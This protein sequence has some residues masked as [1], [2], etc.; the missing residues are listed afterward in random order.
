[1]T[2]MKITKIFVII[3]IVFGMSL[4]PLSS[5]RDIKAMEVNNF[6]EHEDLTDRQKEIIFEANKL[7]EINPYSKEQLVLELILKNYSRPEIH[8]I[9]E[10][11]NINWKNNAKLA[12]ERFVPTYFTRRSLEDRLKQ[13]KFTKEEIEFA[14]LNFEVN[15]S[16]VDW[17]EQAKIIAI[18]KIT[19]LYWSNGFSKKDLVKELEWE[20]FTAE[21]SLNA[22]N[23]F[24]IDWN[25]EAV[26]AAE[27]Y[28]K[29]VIY[30]GVSRSSLENELFRRNF[31]KVEVDF[32]L[33]NAT[34]NGD[35]INWGNQ[36]VIRANTYL[37][38]NVQFTKDQLI[39]F[40]INEKFTE[41]EAVYGAGIALEQ[42]EQ[43]EP[44][45]SAIKALEYANTL[46]ESNEGFSAYGLDM[47]LSKKGFNR[48]DIL[49]ALSKIE[50]D[51]DEQALKSAKYFLNS[52][53]S[54]R[55]ELESMLIRK[56]YFWE[57]VDYVM[58]SDKIDWFDQAKLFLTKYIEKEVDGYTKEDLINVLN[59]NGFEYEEVTHAI[60][61]NNIDWQKQARLLARKY[62]YTEIYGYSKTGLVKKLQQDGFIYIEAFEAV[63]DLN[64]SKK[65][66]N[67]WEEQ[68]LI[69][70]NKLIESAA[71][72]KVSLAKSL[73]WVGFYPKEIDYA[74]EKVIFEEIPVNWEEQA[75]R[76]LE[77]RINDAYGH[78]ESYTKKDWFEYL[79]R[80]KFTSNQSQSAIDSIDI[81]WKNY[82]AQLASIYLNNYLYSQFHL[83][84]NMKCGDFTDDEID[85]ALNNIFINWNYQ[86]VRKARDLVENDYIS[87]TSSLIN[88]LTNTY[89]FTNEQA[90]YAATNSDLDFLAIAIEAAE[91]FI[92]YDII[93]SKEAII[94][95]LI[96]QGFTKEDA[97]AALDFLKYNTEATEFPINSDF[98]D[99]II[100]VGDE[101]N[102]EFKSNEF[103]YN[104]D[105]KWH[106]STINTVRILGCGA[107][108][109]DGVQ[110]V[111]IGI[112]A[113]NPGIVTISLVDNNNEVISQKNLKV[114]K[115]DKPVGPSPDITP[116]PT[117]PTPPV[118][119]A[120]T[121]P[122]EPSVNP[123]D[124]KLFSD[125][126]KD[127][128]FYKYVTY[129]AEK[130]ISTGFTEGDKAGTFG[131]NDQLTRRHAAMLLI[132]ALG[133]DLP[134]YNNTFTDVK[135]GSSGAQHIQAAYDLGLISGYSN[136]D[137][138][139]AYK[140]EETLKRSQFAKMVAIAYNLE[141]DDSKTL[142]LTDLENNTEYNYIKAVLDNKIV[143]GY[144]DNTYG[145]HKAVTRGNV[146]KFIYNAEH[147][148]K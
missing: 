102:V 87:S 146:S 105:Y 117:N 50:V 72:S 82:A 114:I 3:G 127:H 20:K 85:Y 2:T 65:D 57:Q 75:I 86:A 148:N 5:F 51:W 141:K 94:Q 111:G 106:L 129:L 35:L 78:Y 54:T 55:C 68:A 136:S 139:R 135:K 21:E 23:A 103:E 101:I 45:E 43:R 137:R 118:S 115:K 27:Y 6:E 130:D 41:D 7:L 134:E 63:K 69:R 90:V 73:D 133:V 9:L 14:L 64:K 91:N 112:I 99:H 61:E 59:Q 12:N 104:S 32:A 108:E 77:S 37:N 22:V 84:E 18:E 13:A 131:V 120:P 70:A 31:E 98:L 47:E 109:Q 52:K 48:Q 34:L 121:K 126:N 1:M 56:D 19:Y 8:N 66:E 95:E 74:V 116:T 62:I 143:T 28:L 140:P 25:E 145:P 110:V 113:K 38:R 24:D 97:N 30:E 122:S 93:N 36:A 83:I 17:G 15:K 71:Y 44:T 4:K 138:I 123:G 119:D 26:K 89:Q 10:I 92:N 96:W 132:R 33:N 147:L 46:L 40:L 29:E 125:V 39:T 142:K 76:Q 42:L 58:T 16:P 67:L 81:D 11:M 128:E 79:K 60:K 80:E 107:G 100:Y 144:P 124:T 88:S 49:Y 53:P